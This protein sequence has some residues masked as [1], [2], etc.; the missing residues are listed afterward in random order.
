MHNKPKI[1]PS[2]PWR[3]MP[4]QKE[5]SANKSSTNVHVSPRKSS[6]MNECVSR[7]KNKPQTPPSPPWRCI[8]QQKEFSASRSSKK[9]HV[10]PKP[11]RK[12]TNKHQ[13]TLTPPKSQNCVQPKKKEHKQ[14]CSVFPNF[15]E[16]DSHSSKNRLFSQETRT[17]SKKLQT[18]TFNLGRLHHQDFDFSSQRENQIGEFCGWPITACFSKWKGKFGNG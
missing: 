12:P 13:T 3:C 6:P 16:T 2:P 4:Q 10:S 9:A 17:I 14:E 1:Q 15:E 7:K 18:T 5:F 11:R 8:P